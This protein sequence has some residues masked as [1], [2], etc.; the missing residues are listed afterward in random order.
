M[1]ITIN[2]ELNQQNEEMSEREKII[3]DSLQYSNS[4]IEAI[5]DPVFVLSKEGIFLDCKGIR[6]TCFFQKNNL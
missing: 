5:P 4:L 2:E 6:M 3:Y 1:N